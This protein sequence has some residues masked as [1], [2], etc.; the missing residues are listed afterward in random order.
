MQDAELDCTEFQDDPG[1]QA[2][3]RSLFHAIVEAKKRRAADQAASALAGLEAMEADSRDSVFAGLAQPT[4]VPADD[5][6]PGLANAVTALAGATGVEQSEDA[7]AAIQAVAQQLN[8][9]APK[10]MA[11]LPGQ[12]SSVSARPGPYAAPPQQ[13]SSG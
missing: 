3:K 2:G 4:H 12:A 7:I 8:R 6:V 9:V 11:R 1:V 5:T 13:N 10:P